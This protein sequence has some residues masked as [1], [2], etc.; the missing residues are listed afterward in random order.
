M[1]ICIIYLLHVTDI[2]G[3]QEVLEMERKK[4]NTPET[5][6]AQ[7]NNMQ[8]A[9]SSALQVEVE[10]QMLRVV[11]GYVVDLICSINF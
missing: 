8:D 5:I 7:M 6:R 3:L 4:D 9:L 11:G 1:Q 2:N 10:A